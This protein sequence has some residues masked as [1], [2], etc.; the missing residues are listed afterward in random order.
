[1]TFFEVRRETTEWLLAAHCS[2]KQMRTVRP[3][4]AKADAASPEHPL[5]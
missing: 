1:V 2:L 4:L 5:V 3:G